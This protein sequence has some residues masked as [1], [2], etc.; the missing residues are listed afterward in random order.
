MK[1]VRYKYLINNNDTHN[2]FYEM[3]E[4]T[5]NETWTARWGKIGTSG[6]N[7]VT[8]S[9]NRWSEKYNEKIKKGYTDVSKDYIFPNQKS[10]NINIEHTN[11]IILILKTLNEYKNEIESSEELIRSVSI[12]EKML[13]NRANQLSADDMR[14]L[15][16]IWRKIKQYAKK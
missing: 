16:T 10:L 8:Y 13:R 9:M 6:I 1:I 5:D 11:K 7:K 4:N 2:K 12:I 3:I 14:Y 15:N